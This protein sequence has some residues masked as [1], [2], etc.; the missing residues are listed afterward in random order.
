MPKKVVNPS[1]VNLVYDALLKCFWRKEALK[2][3]LRN[4]GVSSKFLS[5]LDANETKRVWLDRLFPLLADHEKGAGLLM[6]MANDL[7][8][9]TS[10]SDLVGWE[11]AEHKLG[12]AKAAVALLLKALGEDKKKRDR[13]REEDDARQ[14]SKEMRMAAIRQ[15]D[16]FDKLKSRMN[17]L[18]AKLGTQ[19]GGYEFEAWFFDL[20]EFE[21]IDN[22][23]PYKVDGRQ[24][25]GSLTLDGTTYLVEL[26]FERDA[27]GATD[28]DSLKAK[29]NSK[30]DN[31]MGIMV[32]MSGY[33]SVA[34]RE[35]SGARTALLLF[36]FNHIYMV[37]GGLSSLKDC[38]LR[39]RRHC[40]QTGHSYL[41]ANEIGG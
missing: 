38:I 4:S 34:I 14:R 20:L 33:T 26:K 13:V 15:K 12:E 40:S 41:A 11:D 24:I 23:R 9:M 35:A 22:R 29:V 3:Y 17:S 6:A 21:D 27:A 19:A 31:T 18:A 5:D 32:A 7:A 10:F 37:L 39:A 2:R 16:D 8:S 25:D 1:I 28:I 36:D 30:A